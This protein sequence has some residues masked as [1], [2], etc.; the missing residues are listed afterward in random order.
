[1]QSIR[2]VLVDKHDL[3]RHGIQTLITRSAYPIQ[4]VGAFSHL[5]E[6]ESCL[7]TE[8]A[9]ILLLDDTLPR[10]LELDH[11][12]DQLRREHPGLNVVILAN[13]L[14]PRYIRRAFDSGARG[15]IYKQDHL[16]EILVLGLKAVW[17]GNT[18]LSPR[19]LTL[20]CATWENTDPDQLSPSDLAV[21]R[22]MGEGYNP[23]EIALQLDLSVRSIYRIYGRLRTLL[24]VRTNEQIVDTARKR[25]LL[26]E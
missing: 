13:R 14:N 12:I 18:Y 5:N 26:D 22:L 23:Q 15:F 3:S 9:H 11:L 21:L 6:A 24:A 1:M 16:E 4:V 2:V 20:F 19:A 8:R 25:G 7:Q 10:S 17:E